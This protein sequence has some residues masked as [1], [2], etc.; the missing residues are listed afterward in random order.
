MILRLP[1]QTGKCYS[2]TGGSLRERYFILIK[3]KESIFGLSR[4][5]ILQ[6]THKV[7]QLLYLFS[8]FRDR[9][10]EGSFTYCH[11][12]ERSRIIITQMR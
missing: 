7:I 3:G 4:N 5:L 9:P 1:L 10:K 11:Q 8:P 12:K 6:A 2:S